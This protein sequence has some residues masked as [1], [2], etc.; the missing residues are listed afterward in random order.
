MKIGKNIAELRARCGLT[1]EDLAAKVGVSRQAVT[2][3]E[4]DESTP[5][6][7]KLVALA[8]VFD[9]SLDKLVGGNDS[10]Y[11]RV[12]ATVSRVASDR[13]FPDNADISP[14]I[15][16]YI[17]YCDSIGLDDEKIVSG[18][19]YICGEDSQVKGQ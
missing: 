5:E 15:R 17:E 6:L 7:S 3:W 10:I 19:L 13:A 12:K 9:V 16:R 18:I 2:K 11:D 4:S 14:V 1:Q 8:D